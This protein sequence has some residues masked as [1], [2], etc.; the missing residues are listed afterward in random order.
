[1]A[2]ID[3]Q[4]HPITYPHAEVTRIGQVVMPV[5]GKPTKC[6]ITRIAVSG[7]FDFWG[8]N[9]RAEICTASSV[10]GYLVRLDLRTTLD[11]KQYEFAFR[12]TN[13]SAANNG[14]T[15]VHSRRHDR[16][17]ENLAWLAAHTCA[18]DTP[19][20]SKDCERS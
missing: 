2:D 6:D 1:M 12:M 3:P 14:S 13:C 20:V 10:P 18:R 5:Q 4:D 19:F 8:D 9:I 11:S 16:L 7:E 15:S 17:V